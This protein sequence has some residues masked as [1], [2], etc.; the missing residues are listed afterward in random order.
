MRVF[1]SIP[2]PESENMA[3]L[4][5]EL[6]RIRGVKITPPEQLHMTLCFIGDVDDG[7]LD[8]ITGCIEESVKGIRPGSI[9]LKGMGVF[10]DTGRPN[11]IWVGASSDIPLKTLSFNIRKNLAAEGIDF[12]GKPFKPHVTVGRIREYANVSGIIK[13][14]ENR[15]FGFFNCSSI[16]IMKSEL[17]P[18]GAK[19][20]L[21]RSVNF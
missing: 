15:D 16:K 10:P 6:S 5:G 4:S 19:H 13:S 20:T 1:I 17:R 21:L 8:T 3:S 7:K 2:V 12:D 18:E 14:N 11:V 9:F